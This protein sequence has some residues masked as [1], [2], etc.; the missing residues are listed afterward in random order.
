MLDQH[1]T[2]KDSQFKVPFN[3]LMS[4]DANHGEQNQEAAV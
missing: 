2:M 3:Y 1:T 4:L